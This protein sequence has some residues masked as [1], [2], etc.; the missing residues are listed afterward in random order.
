MDSKKKFMSMDMLSGKFRTI[1]LSEGSQKGS[2]LPYSNNEVE[3]SKRYV[4]VVSSHHGGFGSSF[5]L[6]LVMA[7]GC[8]RHPLQDN[9]VKQSRVSRST[10]ELIVASP[11][12]P[13]AHLVRDGCAMR[14]QGRPAPF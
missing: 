14:K 1:S 6:L 4:V 13:L 10:Y 11:P 3:E 7:D 12:I 2:S 9:G 8:C 5:V